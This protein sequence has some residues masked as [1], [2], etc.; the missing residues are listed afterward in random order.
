M[1]SWVT[2]K[3][4]I[5]ERTETELLNELK[6]LLTE[7]KCDTCATYRLDSRHHVF[8]EII[9]GGT[10]NWIDIKL[11]IYDEDGEWVGDLFTYDTKDMSREALEQAVREIVKDYYME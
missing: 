6:P 1:I 5:M 8:A 7:T 10:E 9:R 4:A 11:E 3:K 2:D